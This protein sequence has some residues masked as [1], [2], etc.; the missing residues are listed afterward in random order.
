M[1][2]MSWRQY[3]RPVILDVA[4]PPLRTVGGEEIL[5]TVTNAGP[6]GADFPVEVGSWS[7]ESVA[8]SCR[9]LFL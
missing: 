8:Q 5:L 1:S 7:P 9:F 4:A 3:A 2:S 6:G